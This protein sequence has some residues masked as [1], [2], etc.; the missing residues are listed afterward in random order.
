M[1]M[2]EQQ[3]T[4]SENRTSALTEISNAMVRLYKQQFGA[5]PDRRADTPGR[6]RRLGVHPRG[7]THP[8]GAQPGQP[9]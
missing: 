7:H 1:S 8:G 9:G 3:P 5:R 6:S 2:E 4:T